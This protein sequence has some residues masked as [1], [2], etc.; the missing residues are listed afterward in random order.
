MIFKPLEGIIVLDFSQ[1]LSGPSASLRL[2]DLGARVIKIEQPETGDICRHLYNS[3][4]VFEDSSSIFHAINRNK[5]SYQGNLKD[6]LQREKIY[7]LIKKADVLIH[8][9]RPG[10]VNRLG[11]DYDTVRKINDTIIYGEISGYGKEGPWKNKPGQDLL[12]QALSGLTTLSG[13]DGDGPI[14]MG[15]PIVDLIA[16]AHLSQGILACLLRKAKHKIGGLVEVSMLES[17]LEFQFESI[18]TYFHD[19][20][21]PT[22]RTKTN[23]AHPYLGAPYGVYATKD[24]F[25]ALAMGQIPFLGQLLNCPSLL[26]FE[27]PESWYD[28]R[29]EIKKILATHLKTANTLE[30]LAVLEPADIWCANVL[31]W[32][33]LFDEEAFKVLDMIQEIELSE[34]TKFETTRCPIQINDT[35]LWSKAGTPKLGEHNSEIEKEMIL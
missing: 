1:F 9:F 25:L 7:K 33:K 17:V 28:E 32:S 14:P 31:N 21:Q 20:G 13:N 12:L 34:T 3:N 4:V 5:Q 19:G 22:K 16:G 24:G 8:N 30:W 6:E 11:I 27:T 29:D 2:A 10:V 26:N 18:T 15:L 23:N 35:I